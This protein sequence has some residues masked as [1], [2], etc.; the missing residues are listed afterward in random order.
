MS[1]KVVQR[2]KVV[3]GPGAED[4]TVGSLWKKGGC[5]PCSLGEHMTTLLTGED[6]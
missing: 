2:I 4:A 3:H 1:L 6:K 5:S